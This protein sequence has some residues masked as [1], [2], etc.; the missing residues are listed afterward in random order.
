[1]R[2]HTQF[3]TFFAA[4][5][6]ALA[7]LTTVTAPARVMGGGQAKSPAVVAF[8]QDAHESALALLPPA[9]ATNRRIAVSQVHEQNARVLTADNPLSFLSAVA[10]VSGGQ[11]TSSVAVADV[12]GDGNPVLVVLCTCS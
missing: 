5:L 1:M 2:I 10:Y 12:N 8:P 7:A 6:I 11:G 4:V 9:T 3:K